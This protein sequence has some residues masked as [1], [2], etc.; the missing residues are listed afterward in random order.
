MTFREKRKHLLELYR[1][2]DKEAR[3]YLKEAVCDRGCGGCCVTRGWIDATTLEGTI[4]FE[5]VRSLP[6][7][8]RSRLLAG[9]EREMAAKEAGGDAPVR[10]G[11]L[12]DDDICA[13][14]PARPFSCR[15][16][17]SIRRCGDDGA[18]VHKKLWELGE[19]IAIEIQRLDDTGYTG[20][21]SF[22]VHL[23]RQTA[24]RKFYQEG[25]F[26]PEAVREFGE[27]HGLSINRFR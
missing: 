10:C 4:L 14:Y 11:F 9:V 3:P 7:G 26:D 22:I 1:R 8:A 21:L 2:F 5:K 15:R 12:R 25:G 13:V 18:T 16:L 27:A 24:F 17:Y 6:P 20:H 23:L 19:K